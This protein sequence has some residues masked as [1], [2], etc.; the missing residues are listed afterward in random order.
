M[1]YCIVQVLQLHIRVH[2]VEN[3]GLC[4]AARRPMY[5]IV[6]CIYV[7][8]TGPCVCMYVCMCM[9]AYMHVFMHANT[10]T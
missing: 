2:A 6:L 10:A 4:L 8:K 7:C 9:A 1:R 5:V 3:I